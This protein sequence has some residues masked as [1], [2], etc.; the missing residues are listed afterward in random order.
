MQICGCADV[1]NK[2]SAFLFLGV[3][4]NT[5]LVINCPSLSTKS[6][7]VLIILLL[8]FGCNKPLRRNN[9]ITKI[10]LVRTGAWAQRAATTIID[11]SLRYK[12]W[13]YGDEGLEK[14][15]YLIGKITKGFWDTL[16]MKFEKT[17]YKNIKPNVYLSSKDGS[18]YE[19]LIH[20]D[21]NK[22]TIIRSM[23]ISEDSI[24]NICKWLDQTNKSVKLV[25]AVNPFKFETTYNN[26]QLL[27]DS[28]APS[29]SLDK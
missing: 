3:N 6:T 13:N 29:L 15:G 23:N 12:Y 27:P 20:F 28:I 18:F 9:E 7:I 16:N 21:D 19:L 11:N 2:A 10:E 26:L 17:K 25:R 22:E 5:Y 14:S 8:F 1:F 4:G 24:V